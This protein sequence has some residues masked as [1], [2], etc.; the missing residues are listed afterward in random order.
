MTP[1][2]EFQSDSDLADLY[3][4][5]ILDHFRSS[6]HRGKAVPPD[7]S[8]SGVNPLCGDQV[9]LTLR[10]ERDRIRQAR[11]EGQGCVISQASSSI[12]SGALE[13]KTLAEA[14]VLV[15]A[16]KGVMLGSLKTQD[17]PEDLEEAR[18]L[19]GVRK[20]PVRVKCALLCWNTFLEGLRVHQEGD[21]KAAFTERA[22]GG[23]ES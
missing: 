1:P 18:V 21:G 19:E 9:E 16:F 8:A 2:K 13:G 3:R 11:F 23:G 17:L 10:L 20:Y 14:R 7:I 15:E 4:D 22:D 5:V 6:A 12:L